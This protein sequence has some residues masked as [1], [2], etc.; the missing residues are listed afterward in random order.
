VT[1]PVNT[2]ITLGIIVV[3]VP[4]YYV[5]RAVSGRG[6]AAEEAA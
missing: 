3:G 1:D 6:V 4:V 5:W 2:G